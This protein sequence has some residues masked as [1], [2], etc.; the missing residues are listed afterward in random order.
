LF[1]GQL[2]APLDS[3]QRVGLKA[4]LQVTPSSNRVAA[5]GPIHLKITVQNTGAAVWLPT[6]EIP[7]PWWKK[8]VLARFGKRTNMGPD[9]VAPRVGGVRF[10]IQLLDDDANLLDI[11]YFRYHLTPAEGRPIQPGETV[12]L[13]VKV[14]MLRAGT[15][16]LECNMVSEGVCW[17]DYG[18]TP[19]RLPVKVI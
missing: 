9:V 11:D 12:K 6:P 18:G 1:K 17:F 4:D 2:T 15:Y 13:E 19:V 3:R 10:A 7:Q 5:G 14:P 16:L 8:G